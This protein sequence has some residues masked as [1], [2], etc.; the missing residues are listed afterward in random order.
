MMVFI[1]SINIFF[2]VEAM[3]HDE[4]NFGIAVNIEISQLN[5]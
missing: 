1:K 4:L 2:A 3:I 5:F